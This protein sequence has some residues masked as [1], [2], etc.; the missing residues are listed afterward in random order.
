MIYETKRLI[1]KEVS[2]SDANLVLDYYLKNK[3]F[4]D[5]YEGFKQRDFYTLENQ[6]RFL[7]QDEEVMKQGKLVRL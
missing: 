1:L 7:T 3:D 2:K 4:L 5:K 6:I